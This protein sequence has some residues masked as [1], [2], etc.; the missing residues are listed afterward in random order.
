MNSK[1]AWLVGKGGLVL[2]VAIVSTLEQTGAGAIAGDRRDAAKLDGGLL[3]GTYPM[4]G[5]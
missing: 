2:L 5:A 1:L 3:Q 4:S